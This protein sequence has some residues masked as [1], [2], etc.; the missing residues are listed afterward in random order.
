MVMKSKVRKAVRLAPVLA[1]LSALAMVAACARTNGKTPISPE[2]REKAATVTSASL[3]KD[4]NQNDEA[5]L[6]FAEHFAGASIIVHGRDTEKVQATI[7]LMFDNH[8]PVIVRGMIPFGKENHAVDMPNA[9]QNAKSDITV[10][11]GCGGSDCQIVSAQITLKQE[12]DEAT[13][14]ELSGAKGQAELSA[15]AKAADVTVTSTATADSASAD[16]AG[17]ESTAEVK[18]VTVVQR[19]VIAFTIMS[20]ASKEE[21]LVQKNERLSKMGL[22]LSGRTAKGPG[23]LKSFEDAF[24]AVTGEDAPADEQVEVLTAS[25]VKAEDAAKDDVPAQPAPPEARDEQAGDDSSKEA[26]AVTKPAAA[27]TTTADEKAV[28]AKP[29]S[30]QQQSSAASKTATTAKPAAAATK[31]TTTA[32]K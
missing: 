25:P 30:T 2:R 32:A 17:A 23:S 8:D 26:A 19:N 11:A 9:D 22:I 6:K 13:A 18:K 31:S 4:Y 5:N 3:F 15:M 7:K 20:A 16:A 12:V 10:Q 21:T 28:D 1:S 29:A 27:S 24:R 14:Q